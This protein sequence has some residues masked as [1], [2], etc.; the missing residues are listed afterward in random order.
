MKKE[1]KILDKKFEEEKLKKELREG[2]IKEWFPEELP[3]KELPPK[4]EEKKEFPVKKELTEK[5]IEVREKLKEEI[6]KLELPT[7]KRIAVLKESEKIK[8]QTV[9]RQIDYLL[10]LAQQKGLAFAIKAANATND[11]FLID[12]FHDILAKRGL[13]KNFQM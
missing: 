10:F 5:E 13:Y 2:V 7:Q 9:Q 3:P 8:K 6:K 4:F 11:P 12:L 1:N